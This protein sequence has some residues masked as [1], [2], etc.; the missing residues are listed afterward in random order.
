MEQDMPLWWQRGIIY[1]I[2]PRSFQDS[3]HDGIGDLAGAIER[4]DYLSETLGVDAIWLSPFYPSPM[5]DFGYDVSNYVDIHPMF[6]DLPTFDWL[7]EQAHR[8]DLKVIVDFVPNHTS[9]QHPWFLESR[10][11]RDSAK[12][13]WY[14]W[15]DARADGS[16]PNNWLAHFGGGAWEW[17]DATQQYYLH[18]F[19]REQPDVNWRNPDLRNAMLDVLRF[20]MERGVDGFRIDVAHLIMKDP[21]LRDNPPN[22]TPPP[23]DRPHHAY[24]RLLHVHDK[25]HADVHGAFREIRAV[26]DAYSADQPRMAVGEIHEFDWPVWAGYYGADL[27]ELHMPFNF[28]LIFSAWSAATVKEIVDHVE[29]VVPPGGWPNY[30]LGNHDVH[31]IA[32]RVGSEQARVAM[33][34]LLTLR[35]TPTIYYGDEIGMHDVEI[36]PHMI[37]DP[38][39]KNVPGLGLG[40]DPERTPMQWDAGPHAGFCAP[41]VEPWLPIAEDHDRVNVAIESD[42]PR[43]MLSLTRALVQTRRSTPA[44]S[45]G[46]YCPVGQAP[47]N[48]FVYLREHGA[49]RRLIA[50]NFSDQEETVSMTDAGT[51]SIALSTYLD[52]TGPVDLT[53]LHLR[54]NEG[55]IIEVGPAGAV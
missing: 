41:D 8:R 5:A 19:L 18:S 40:R 31:R 36:P 12:R 16:P 44:L 1:Q 11:S 43:S 52:R 42:D 29:E 23:L 6:G 46:I 53:A 37:Q 26:L 4:L 13:D 10:S 39:E 27:D 28:A 54:P 30:V 38:Y 15:A 55:C 21:D 17:D 3:N 9:D 20:W 50:L 2:Y 35:G 7:V 22:P 47:A 34:L 24:D 25:A 33:M 49:T 51:G 45:A 48:C 32:T 14:V